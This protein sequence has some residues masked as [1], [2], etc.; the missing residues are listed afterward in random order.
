MSKKKRGA[1][2]G[3]T[4]AIKHGLY[5]HKYKE[6]EADALDAVVADGLAN[7]IA[8]LRVGIRRVF[9]YANEHDSQLTGWSETLNTLGAAATRLAHLIRTQNL[10]S[11]GKGISP[12]LE[13]LSRF[14]KDILDEAKHPLAQTGGPS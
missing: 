7:E 1:Q 5:S 2:L 14:S 12:I 6:L 4:N 11:G 3:N 13:T 10:I 8:L 9:E